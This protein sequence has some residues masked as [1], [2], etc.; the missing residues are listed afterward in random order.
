MADLVFGNPD[1]QI[2]LCTINE[3]QPF[4]FSPRIHPPFHVRSIKD[5]HVVRLVN[6]RHADGFEVPR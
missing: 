4:S 3:I 6:I 2:T 1:L 5:D